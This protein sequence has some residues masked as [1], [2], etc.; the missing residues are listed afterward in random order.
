MLKVKDRDLVIAGQLIGDDIRHDLSCFREDGRVFSSIKGMI[1]LNRKR[2]R[3]VPSNGVYLPKEGDVIIGVITST[4]THRLSV[5]INSPYPG[6]ILVEDLM[7]N[8][9]DFKKSDFK[10][11][12]WNSQG[13]SRDDPS[14]DYN[15]G[16]VVSAKI[17]AVDEIYSSKLI[18][19]WKLKGGLIIDVNPKRIPRVVGKRRSML[20]MIKEMTGCKIIV[21][22]NGKIW[23]N[24]EKT[25]LVIRTM[26]KI[27]REAQTSGLTNRIEAM[28]NNELGGE[29]KSRRIE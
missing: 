12:S 25:D 20:N 22:Q 16:D 15:I 26:R 7:G 5:D 21:G 4:N 27:E 11:S 8:S 3:I 9:R 13:N 14:E 23:I 2:A 6:S 10:K 24:G 17:S 1:T 18:R 28:L 19:P 29:S